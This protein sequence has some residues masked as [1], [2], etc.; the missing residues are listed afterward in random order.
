LK[1]LKQIVIHRYAG[2]PYSPKFFFA[3]NRRGDYSGVIGSLMRYACKG[4]KQ[5]GIVVNAF[6]AYTYWVSDKIT[7]AQK[8]K[9]LTAVKAAPP[10]VADG[11]RSRLKAATRS[12]VGRH[13]IVR[14]PNPLVIYRGSPSKRAPTYHT[15][16]FPQSDSI[17]EEYSLMKNHS[18][19]MH[20]RKYWSIYN[21]MLRGTSL[22]N[23]E[24]DDYHFGML[25]YH[26][27]DQYNPRDI[28]VGEVHFLQEPGYKLR[29]IASPYR[30]FQVAT[31]PLK[32][33]LKHIVKQLEWDCT[34]DQTKA[35]PYVQK[36]LSDGKTVYSV[37]LSS[38]TD[39]FPLELQRLVLQ[40]IFGPD[41]PNVNLFCELSQGKFISELGV[42]HWNRGQPLGF[43][44]SFFAFTLTHGL[45]LASLLGKPYNHEFFVVGDDVII[46]DKLLHDR[47]LSLLSDLGCPYSP[48]KSLESSTIA[49]FAG[50]LI[51]S[52][53]IISQMKW[54]KMSDDNFLDL[55]R[56]YGPRIKLLLSKRQRQV[57][58]RFAHV[59]DFIHGF[60]LNW[61][62]PG[63]NL[64]SMIEEGLSLSFH[65]SALNSL[66]GISRTVLHNLYARSPYTTD[67][68]DLIDLEELQEM[69]SAFDEKVVSVFRRV[70][71]HQVHK[72]LTP[73]LSDLPRF[74]FTIFK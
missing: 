62:K 50:K 68:M 59:P 41:D 58:E 12:Y 16:K 48:D 10:V 37:D 15:G 14:K 32:I 34:H 73:L 52:N 19:A 20:M 38:A 57:L 71:G 55:A 47:Y 36:A 11:V 25:K 56:L 72:D 30:L 23:C 66:T 21:E 33:S 17:F 61:S 49:E 64:S 42:I 9:F 3:K 69:S 39:Y 43:N 54:R 2:R 51:T 53:E 46:M 13:R 31:E 4:Q 63:S 6:M 67:F 24:E 7:D 45:L 22:H 5:L 35:W 8:D 29:S 1:D 65:E 74:I 27:G 26:F 18:V 28:P 70:M 44:P 40:D 60:G